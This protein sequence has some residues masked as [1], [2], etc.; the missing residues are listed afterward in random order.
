[1]S[2]F[3]IFIE[4]HK[5]RK[6]EQD[7]EFEKT[8]DELDDT[9]A[10]LLMDFKENVKIGG[11]SREVSQVFFRRSQKTIF[12]ILIITKGRKF[13][14]FDFLSD[15]LTH[16]STFVVAALQNVFS[17]IEFQQLKLKSLSAWMDG[18]KHFRNFHLAKYFLSLK[19]HQ[20]DH[21][22][23]NYFIEYHGKNYCDGH[24][25]LINK[26]M[27]DHESSAKECIPDI[28]S[29]Q[30]LLQ[31]KL[32]SYHDAVISEIQSRQESGKRP[33]KRK[34]VE[35]KSMVIILPLQTRSKTVDQVNFKEFTVHYSF[36]VR[37]S[38]QLELKLTKNVTSSKVVTVSQNKRHRKKEPKTKTSPPL[39][40]FK[41]PWKEAIWVKEIKRAGL[42][43]QI[44]E[45]PSDEIYSESVDC[46]G[47][48]DEA[49][50]MEIDQ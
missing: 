22:D 2:K 50:P 6:I 21:V 23:W 15:D 18:A 27:E 30:N 37:D 1:M 43:G 24:F 20:F 32:T 28:Y 4:R 3:D 41:K 8:I 11:S 14:F 26:I 5:K 13:Q 19:G 10:V 31:S 12:S 9:S 46:G 25:A 40:N 42:L 29:L 33:L 39:P 47:V 49:V 38:H 16:D 34:K 7:D 36:I 48:I 35:T 17:S 44:L 45:T